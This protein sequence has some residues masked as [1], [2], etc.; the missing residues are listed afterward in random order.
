MQEQIRSWRWRLP[1]NLICTGDE[2]SVAVA[3]K[4]VVSFLDE[5]V[6]LSQIQDRME[7][8]FTGEARRRASEGQAQALSSR[9]EVKKTPRNSETSQTGPVTP[10]T[11]R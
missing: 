7:S 4:Q 1:Q 2:P 5:V 8:H 6:D 9:E 3:I 11:S 10:D